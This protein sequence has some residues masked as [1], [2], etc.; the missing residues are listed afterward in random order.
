MK[1][2]DE[3]QLQHLT[4]HCGGLALSSWNRFMSELFHSFTGSLKELRLISAPMSYNELE[5]FSALFTKDRSLLSLSMCLTMVSPSA[6]DLLAAAFPNIE[7]LHVSYRSIRIEQSN[8][9]AQGDEYSAF[10]KKMSARHY[11]DWARGLR[12]FGVHQLHASDDL[13]LNVLQLCEDSLI[14]GAL[15]RACS[16]NYRRVA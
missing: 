6:L 10:V 7:E 12:R 4:F 11:T 16:R 3:A 1:F 9:V 13:E 8:S 14:L 5:R 2:G 15:S